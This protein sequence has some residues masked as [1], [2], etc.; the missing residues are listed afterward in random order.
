MK[1]HV[2]ENTVKAA[3]IGSEGAFWSLADG[4]V[5]SDKDWAAWV[6]STKCFWRSEEERGNSGAEVAESELVS[7]LL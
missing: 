3:E 2:F 5:I 4:R 6:E 7:Q 1:S